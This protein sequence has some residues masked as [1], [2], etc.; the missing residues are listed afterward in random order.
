VPAP[1]QPLRGSPS[2]AAAGEGWGGGRHELSRRFNPAT[3]RKGAWP[4]PA[5]LPLA[6]RR[7]LDAGGL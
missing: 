4:G 3:K 6:W 5:T 2:P 7:W 1:S